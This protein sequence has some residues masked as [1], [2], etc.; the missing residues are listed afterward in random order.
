M[1]NKKARGVSRRSFLG[2]AA[3]TAYLL[4]CSK[5]DDY[6]WRASEVGESGDKTIVRAAI[7]PGIGVARIG[8]STDPEGFFVGP[9]VAEPP[10]TMAGSS[11]DRA[12][13]IKRQAARFR[14]YGYNAAG[15][16]VRE[17][18]ADDAEVTWEVHMAN[19]KAQWY[20]FTTALDIPEAK[21]LTNSIRRNKTVSGN[22]RK[23]LAID[24]G[25]KKVTGKNTRGG[26]LDGG[27][28]A[29][30]PVSLGEIRTDEGGRLLVLGGLGRSGSPQNAP[31]FDPADG[32]TFNNADG[33]YDDIA[34]GPVRATVRI[35]GKDIP[36]DPAW[37]FVAPPNYAPDVV[38]FRTLYDLLVET[39][40][41]AGMLTPPPTTSF[42][43]DVLPALRRLSNL[44]WVNKGFEK[45]HQRG[46]A[47]DF[48]DPELLSRL[49][50]KDG[51]PDLRQTV[52]A[53]F[54]PPSTD[55]RKWPCMYGDSYDGS[56][57]PSERRDFAISKLRAL[58]LK[59]WA[60][61]DYEEDWSRDS[62]AYQKLEDVP[63]GEQPAMLDR[64]ALHFCL[65][66]AFHPGCEVTWPMRHAS[67]YS[68]PFRIRQR[69]AGEDEPDYGDTLT[70]DIVLKQHGPLYAQ[71][72]GD[73]TK[74][75]ALPWQGDTAFCRSGYEKD[76]DP[77]LPTFWPARVP[78]H[79]LAEADYLIA[80]NPAQPRDKRIAAFRNRSSW[81]RG[82]TG[83]AVDQMHQM[84]AGFGKM[85]IIEARPGVKGDRE[86]PEVM[87]VETLPPPGLR[88]PPM[89]TTESVPA[90][91]PA[92][93]PLQAAGWSSQAQLD[94]FLAILKRPK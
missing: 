18:T 2:G 64:A 22:A 42:T 48:D 78:N 46:T 21:D 57:T 35:S 67:L 91:D 77:Y 62:K 50:K 30:T 94:D 7:H 93:S 9:E 59:R 16:I 31:I 23:D 5:Q 28:F 1:K 68:A 90:P 71:S 52:R 72:P 60:D 47:F 61:G 49:A 24:P 65:A 89:A 81:F 75:M 17:I 51:A 39:Y 37:V 70:Q 4:G 44:Q 29:G 88:A 53:A 38:G 32:D 10:L 76:F 80:I 85:G 34:D 15:Q 73:L 11:R 27:K 87:F 25:A 12:G 40:V 86:L 74:W 58:H 69:P 13:A 82:L 14:I 19:K 20:R 8:N 26:K 66:D 63:L 54:R 84:V 83:M 3:A 79:V 6:E 36:V 45:E 55:R 43:Q 56:G 41:E 33:W 92:V